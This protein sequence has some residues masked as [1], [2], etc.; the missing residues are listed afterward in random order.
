MVLPNL[1]KKREGIIINVGNSAGIFK[2]GF[3]AV[4]GGSNCFLNY[5]TEVLEAEVKIDTQHFFK[6]AQNKN[7]NVN[8]LM[9]NFEQDYLNDFGSDACQKPSEIIIQQVNCGGFKDV[10]KY[11]GLYRN[12]SQTQASSRFSVQ[13][14][15][16][17]NIL[18]NMKM[19]AAGHSSSI[20]IEAIPN[21][22]NFNFLIPTAEE[23]VDSSIKTVG[24]RTTTFGYI[25]HSLY[26]EFLKLGLKIVPEWLYV[27]FTYQKLF[28]SEEFR[29]RSIRYNSRQNKVC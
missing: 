10:N 3:H 4:F 13:K 6:A 24:Y 7:L 2:T 27:K 22:P 11:G 25:W 20:E 17:G 9:N 21:L 23:F 28:D 12:H 8:Y 16:S 19:K 18:D 29:R 5:F 15:F 14:N 1:I 26:F